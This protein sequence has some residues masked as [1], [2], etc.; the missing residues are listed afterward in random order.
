MAKKHYEDCELGQ[1]VCS[2]A[3][4]ITETD[5]VQFAYLAGDWMPMHTDEEYAR[6]SAFGQRVAHGMLILVVTTALLTRGGSRGTFP[7]QTLA[8]YGLDKVRFIGPTKIGDTVRAESEVTKVQEL[9]A[10]RGLLTFLVA[11]K[12][13]RDEEVLRFSIRILAARR[14]A[15]P[16]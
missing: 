3:R 16:T 2:P 13:Q 4:T 14:A 10:E 12:N 15:E 7:E 1:Q 9:D 11:V 6:Q 8:L 5:I